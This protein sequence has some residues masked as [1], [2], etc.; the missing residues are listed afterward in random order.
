MDF[1]FAIENGA[2]SLAFPCF[3][4]NSPGKSQKVP[5]K[6]VFDPPPETPI[7]LLASN[8]TKNAKKSKKHAKIAPLATRMKKKS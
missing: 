6:G 2:Y 5:K 3:H 1:G 4:C 8:W 7:L